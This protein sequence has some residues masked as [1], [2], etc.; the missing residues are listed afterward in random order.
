M[1]DPELTNLRIGRRQRQAVC[2]GVGEEGGVKVAAQ[3]ALLAEVHP[4]FK[5]LGLQLVAV[6]PLTLF[7][8]G[9]GGVEIHLLGAG[10][11]LQHQIQIGHQLFRGSCLSGI[12]AGGLNAAGE[13]LGGIGIKATNIVTLPAVQRNRNTLQ[14]FDGSIGI[15]AQR[16]IFCFCF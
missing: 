4:F 2:L 5:V 10:A 12:V 15:H 11:K 6:C 9:V 1:V 14:F 8:N 16:T 7:K 3:A 13:G